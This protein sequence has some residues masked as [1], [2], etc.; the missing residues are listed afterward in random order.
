MAAKKLNLTIRQ[1]E[2]FIRVI[3]WETL[4]FVYKAITAI[5]NAAPV[6]ITAVGH[7]LVSGWRAAVISAGGMDEINALYDPPRDSDFKQVTAIDADNIEINSVNSAEFDQYTSGGYL[8]YYTPV[9]LA[10]YSAR[11]TVRNKIGGTII[12][13]FTSGAP[14]NR[15]A[16]DDANHTITLTIAATDSDDLDFQTGVYDLELVG[17]TGVVTTLY[18]GTVTLTREV[19]T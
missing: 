2:T 15:I 8:K 10:G 18:Y 6:R 7:G 17:P 12:I 4:P 11:M 16:L 13:Q 19:T 14:D 3:R 5:T 1:G 9:S